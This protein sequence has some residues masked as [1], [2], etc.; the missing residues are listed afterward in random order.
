MSS[1][2]H[3]GGPT[4]DTTIEVA[5]GAASDA[6]SGIDGYSFFFNGVDEDC[7]GTMDSDFDER[8]TT[9]PPLAAG[10]W[11]FHVCAVDLAGNW[12]AVTT[13]G[14]YTIDLSAPKVTNVDSVVTSGGAIGEGEVV[15]VEIT[16][17]LVTF[18]EAMDATLAESSGQLPPDLRRQ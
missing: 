3:D 10:T 15:N 16:Q 7:D 17:L 11:Y 6:L 12:G 5:W 13:G 18:D 2:S 14:P 4:N 9:S 1:S 8:T